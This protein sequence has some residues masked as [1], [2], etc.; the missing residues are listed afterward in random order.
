VPATRHSNKTRGVADFM[1]ANYGVAPQNPL[2]TPSFAAK[3]GCLLT[4]DALT[5]KAALLR[6]QSGFFVELAGGLVFQVATFN[7]VLVE[8]I[9]GFVAILLGVVAALAGALAATADMG[10]YAVAG[11]VVGLHVGVEVA[12]ARASTEAVR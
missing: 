2:P 6:E 4:T 8:A 10:G 5:K 7:V 1:R 3:M 12:I 11:L 9:G